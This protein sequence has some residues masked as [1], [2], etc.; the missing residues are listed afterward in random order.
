[1]TA[2]TC[3]DVVELVTAYLEGTLS[4]EDREL[5]E[6]HLEL[7]DGCERYLR[8]MK[9]TIE[10]IGEVQEDSLSPRTRQQ[11]LDAFTGWKDAGT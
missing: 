11:L 9:R 7:C 4:A 1:M 8:Q 5:F 6:Q 3:Q 10:L 2:M